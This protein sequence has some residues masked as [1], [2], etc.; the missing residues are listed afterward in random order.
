MTVKKI[1]KKKTLKNGKT[2]FSF[3]NE[4]EILKEKYFFF[5]TK[6]KEKF[7]EKFSKIHEKI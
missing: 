2:N 5:E 7:E 6:Y 4:E 1:K 3:E